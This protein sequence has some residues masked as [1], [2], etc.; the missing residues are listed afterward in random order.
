MGACKDLSG[1]TYTSDQKPDTH[2]I[3]MPMVMR[4][5][6]GSRCPEC[7]RMVPGHALRSAQVKAAAM[8][9]SDRN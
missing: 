5:R 2:L 8:V 1:L 7:H 9:T 6:F 3:N 4:A